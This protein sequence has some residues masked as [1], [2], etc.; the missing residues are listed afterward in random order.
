MR[1]CASEVWSFG[2]SRNDGL[3]WRPLQLCPFRQQLWPLHNVVLQIVVGNLA[4]RALHAPTHGDASFMHGVGIARDQR[5]PPIE[6]A[7]F[8][9]ETIATARRQPAEGSH[10]FGSEANAIGNLGGTVLVI[11]AGT[12]ARIEQAAGDVGEVDLAGILVFELFQA[13]ARA[14]VAQALP[15]GV[16]HFLQ[17]LGFPEESLLARDSFGGCGHD[18]WF[19]PGIVR[20]PRPSRGPGGSGASG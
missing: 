6:I 11:L 10:I 20:F 8:G 16:G 3:L 17:R 9:D 5:M 12:G 19:L 4:F 15:F 1:N 13:A 18:L 2:P 14:T 7:A